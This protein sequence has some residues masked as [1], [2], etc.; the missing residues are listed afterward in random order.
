MQI[1]YKDAKESIKKG[2]LNRGNVIDLID[3]MVRRKHIVTKASQIFNNF[4]LSYVFCCKRKTILRSSKSI[5]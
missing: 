1:M 5:K 4:V 2:R 3:T